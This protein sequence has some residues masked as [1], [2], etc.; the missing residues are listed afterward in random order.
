DVGL[1]LVV[2]HDDLDL[3]SAELAAEILDPEQEAVAQ[4]RAE[5]RG[6]SRERRDKSDLEL[7]LRLRG[8]QRQQT[9]RGDDCGCGSH[10]CLSPVMVSFFTSVVARS[11]SNSIRSVPD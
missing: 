10:T 8:R 6:R 5:H 4:L 2:L 9:G 11:C 7:L 1:E 3:A